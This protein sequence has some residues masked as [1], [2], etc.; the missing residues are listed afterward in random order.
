MFGVTINTFTPAIFIASTFTPKVSRN[1]G[2]VAM[3]AAA[4]AATSDFH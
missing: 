1:C 3:T 2:S 4:S